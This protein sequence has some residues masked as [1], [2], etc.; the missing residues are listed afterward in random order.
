MKHFMLV[1]FFVLLTV[2]VYM[3]MNKLYKRYPLSLLNPILTATIGIIS[4]LSIFQITYPTYMIGG[5]WINQLLGPAIVALAFPLHKQ[6][7]NL[8]KHYKM[9]LLGVCTGV[10][11][12]MCSGILI[13]QSFGVTKKMLASLLPKSLTTPV[14]IEISAELGGI[15]SMTAVFV[16]TAGLTGAILGPTILRLFKIHNP[17]SK[18][19]ALGSA[20]HAIGTSKALELGDIPFSMS[21]V[22]M[23][24]SAIL[25]SIIGPVIALLFKI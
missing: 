14:A 20:S 3:C 6:R 8:L 10:I 7:K 16:M 25:G 4:F 17:V 9:I 1:L 5:D 19:V 13:A 18:G 11:A 2:F 22:S 12:G 15:P 21:S 24:L 23:T